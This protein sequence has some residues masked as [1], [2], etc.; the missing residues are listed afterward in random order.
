MCIYTNT[1]S[2]Q[3]SDD[4]RAKGIKRNG[5]ALIAEYQVNLSAYHFRQK[6]HMSVSLGLVFPNSNSYIS[7]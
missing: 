2:S 6:R 5:T 1:Y 3:Y 4:G 7:S